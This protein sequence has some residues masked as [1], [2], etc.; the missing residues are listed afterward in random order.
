MNI[1]FEKVNKVDLEL[2]RNWRMNENVTKY[3]LTD[4]II[5][6]N[7]QLNWYKSIK[8][9]IT[10][11]DYL[12]LVDDDKIGYYG[13]TN[14]EYKTFSCEIGFY[15][16]NDCYRGKGLFREIQK[17]AEDIIVNELKLN[18]IHVR[19]LDENPILKTYL[20][21]GFVEDINKRIEYVKK[22]KKYN[23]LYLDKNI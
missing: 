7:D 6:R 23:L 10:R 1:Q 22:N 9:D 5:S 16:G 21:I 3:L 13:I 4:P 17:I 18:I 20:N 8:K 12:I 2:L 19:V 14:I 11:R 15:I